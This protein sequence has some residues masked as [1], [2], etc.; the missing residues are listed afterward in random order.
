MSYEEMLELFEDVHVGLSKQ[1]MD[2]FP[3]L[4]Y[5]KIPG[6]E[7]ECSICLCEF[8]Q[9]EDVMKLT[10]LHQFHPGCIKQWLEQHST[11]PIC[12]VSQRESDRR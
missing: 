1:Q 2:A 12:R 5:Q 9:D 3:I 4:K 8:E 6:L 10:C 7:S 11:C